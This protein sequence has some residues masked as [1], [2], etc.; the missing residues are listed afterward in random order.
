MAHNLAFTNGVANMAYQGETPWH[1]LGER[2]TEATMKNPALA[3]ELAGLTWTT[4]KLPLYLANGDKM[5]GVYAVGRSDGVIMDQTVGEQFTVIDLADYDEVGNVLCNEFGCSVA[6][7]GALGK[8]ETFF[9]LYRMP[10]ADYEVRPG[11][12]TKGYFG[13]ITGNVGNRAACFS[14]QTIRTVCQNTLPADVAGTGLRIA[15]KASAPARLD[16]CARI[17]KALMGQMA[18]QN[19]TFATMARHAMDEAQIAAY[20]DGVFV[21]PSTAKVSDTLADRRATVARLVFSGKGADLAGANPEAHTATLWAVYNAITEYLDHVRP[22]E[23]G[24]DSAKLAANTSAIFG[25]AVSTKVNA[26][27]LARELVTA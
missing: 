14:P 3:R 24:T 10:E 1:K 22:A 19:D 8:G 2:G 15:H 6:T 16:E 23:A 12:Y 11:D 13:L 21:A 5:Q 4:A 20:I 25:N 7:I 18:K 17:V 9:T 26:L 27:A